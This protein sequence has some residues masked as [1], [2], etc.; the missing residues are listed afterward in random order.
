M[1]R[2]ALFCAVTRT[3]LKVTSLRVTGTLAVT[4][5][6]KHYWPDSMAG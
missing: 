1:G 3:Q 5:S 4:N 6:R 2:Q